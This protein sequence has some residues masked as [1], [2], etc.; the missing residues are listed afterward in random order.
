MEYTREAGAALLAKLAHSDLQ[1][2]EFVI[3]IADTWVTGYITNISVTAGV[4]D[5]STVDLQGILNKKI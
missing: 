1:E 3:K 2:G 5:F 4:N